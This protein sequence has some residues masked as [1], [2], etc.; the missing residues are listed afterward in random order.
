MNDQWKVTMDGMMVHV[1]PNDTLMTDYISNT[2]R[3][4]AEHIFSSEEMLL[5]KNLPL[6]ALL[7]FKEKIDSE[8]K[9]RD[10][11]TKPEKNDTFLGHDEKMEK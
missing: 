5:L 11:T 10:M 2:T 3:Q 4:I 7:L 9:R 6:P 1:I 8:I